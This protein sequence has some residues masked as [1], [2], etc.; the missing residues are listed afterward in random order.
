M[1]TTLGTERIRAARLIGSL[2]TRI[3]I[4]EWTAALADSGVLR[5]ATPSEATVERIVAG[6]QRGLA[7]HLEAPRARLDVDTGAL[8]D[9]A[10][11]AHVFERGVTITQ[12]TEGVFCFLDVVF[13]HLEK[14]VLVD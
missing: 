14:G 9:D 4:D 13:V 6:L 11:M 5:D 3:L 12:I 1:T 8:A 10:A 2:D 7:L